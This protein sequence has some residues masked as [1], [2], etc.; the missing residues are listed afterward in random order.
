MFSEV[1]ALDIIRSRLEPKSIVLGP[2]FLFEATLQG[3]HLSGIWFSDFDQ[4]SILIGSQMFRSASDEVTDAQMIPH[5]KNN[6]Q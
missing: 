1:V 2:H 6:K 5:N 3:P 4:M